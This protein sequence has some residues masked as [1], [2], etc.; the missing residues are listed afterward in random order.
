MYNVESILSPVVFITFVGGFHL[1]WNKSSESK[2]GIKEALIR[3]AVRCW[4][5]SK[6]ER[7]WILI[8]LPKADI[9]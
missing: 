9:D 1:W 3:E 4:R 2:T 8:F 5:A 7:T 6:D